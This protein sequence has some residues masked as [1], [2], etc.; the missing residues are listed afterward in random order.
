MSDEVTETGKGGRPR[1]PI[2]SDEVFQAW[3]YLK[4]HLGDPGWEG[5]CLAVDDMR[6]QLD[7]RE[8]FNAIG[9]DRKEKDELAAELQAW[10]ERNLNDTGWKR[11]RNAIRQERRR[12]RRATTTVTM[13]QEVARILRHTS[14]RRDE[15]LSQ[16]V[17]RA[18]R[19]LADQES[20]K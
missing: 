18:L 9:V 12:R 19:A 10:A 14:T 15:T 11:L 4:E 13:S 16:T 20:S 6:G 17:E 3:G 1:K 5:M 7:T 2:E 8:A